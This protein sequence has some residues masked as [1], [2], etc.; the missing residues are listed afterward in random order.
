MFKK[1]AGYSM[2]VAQWLH[3]ACLACARADVSSPKK[4]KDVNY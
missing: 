4:K 2:E 1:R 3:S